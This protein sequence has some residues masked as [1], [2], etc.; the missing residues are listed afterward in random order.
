MA[1]PPAVTPDRS[2]RR[3][4]VRQYR[5]AT[6]V[7]AAL[8]CI[9][10]I[11]P[12]GYRAF[13][14]IYLLGL[15]AL[16][17]RMDRGPVLAA[18][19]LSALAWDFFVIPP[20]YSFRILE[21]DDTVMFG[22]YV[23]VALITTELTARIRLQGEHLGAAR[24]RANSLAK[25]DRLHRALFDSVSHELKIPVTVLRTA[26]PALRRSTTGEQ[27]ELA[28]EICQA[29]DRL[30]RVVGN[31]L[32]QARLESGMLVPL[33]DW[34]DARDLIQAACSS[35]QKVLAG[36]NVQVEIADDTVLLHVDTPLMEQAIENILLN[37]A[38][39]S[40]AGT[41]ITIKSGVDAGRNRAFISVEDEGPGIPEE[42]RN[43]IFQKFQRASSSNPGGLGLGLSIVQGFVAVQGGEV[44]AEN[45]ERAGAKFTIYLPIIPCETVPDD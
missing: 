10:W 20:R 25:A 27:A 43:K 5:E 12:V 15:V 42:L 17:L 22:A 35:V 40:P 23:I 30:E 2:A 36:R 29:T 11:S 44:V 7:I 34:C 26:C 41:T 3:L 18:A 38:L 6:C 37:A 31:L 13:S 45:N 14:L 19:I 9:A 21:F 28:E 33:L 1:L 8:T 32:D 16:S 39:Y 24:E 4:L